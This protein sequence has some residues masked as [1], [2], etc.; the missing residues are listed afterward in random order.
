MNCEFDLVHS[1]PSDANT[2]STTLFSDDTDDKSLKSSNPEVSMS[3]PQ[4]DEVRIFFTGNGSFSDL[5]NRSIP[6]QSNVM[7]P[8]RPVNTPHVT[9][10][11]D[12]PNIPEI[13]EQQ[14]GYQLLIQII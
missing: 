14:R 2:N 6:F 5:A 11:D 3:I 12:R 9:L 7:I 1:D 4:E 10:S 8:P 13:N